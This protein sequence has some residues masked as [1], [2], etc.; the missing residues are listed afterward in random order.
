MRPQFIEFCRTNN[1]KFLIFQPEYAIDHVLSFGDEAF[2]LSDFESLIGHLSLAIVIFPEAPGSFAEA[3]YFS[4][5]EDLA[6]KSILILDQSR[7]GVDSF[8]SIGPGKLIGDKTRFHPSIQME[9]STP[10]FSLIIKRIKERGGVSR[11]KGFPT[12]TFSKTDYFEKLTLIYC[13]FDL[14][15]IS[16]VDDVFFIMKGLFSGRADLK[17]V[18]QLTSILLGSE[19]IYSVGDTRDFS[20][21]KIDLVGCALRDGYNEERNAL[22]I[23]VANLLIDIGTLDGEG[24]TDAA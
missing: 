17:Q 6:K 8:L 1:V 22:K 23:E 5:I 13:I 3:G 9:Y 12:T 24:A 20:A 16:T 2:N 14:L 11:R 10:D 7:L 18:Q 4:A 15:E 21:K 19:L